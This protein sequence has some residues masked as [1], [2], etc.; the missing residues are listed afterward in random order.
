MQMK[1]RA[2][3][4]WSRHRVGPIRL[5]ELV[6]VIGLISLLLAFALWRLLPLRG[7]AEAAHVT[8]IIGGL[9]SAVGLSAAE[10]LLRDG[11]SALADFDGANPMDLLQEGPERYRG[12]VPSAERA[13]VAPGYWYFEADS[14]RLGYR[15]RF[16]QYLAEPRSGP[17]HLRWRLSLGFDDL[18]GSGRFNPDTDIVRSL[19]LEPEQDWPWP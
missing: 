5:L 7:H 11:L 4:S 9:R 6:V 1:N 18:D 14:G 16:P 10:T 15:V 8:T 19:V 3:S 12:L 13:G 17:V 2:D